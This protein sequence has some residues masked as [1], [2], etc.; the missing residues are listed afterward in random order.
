MGL[1]DIYT[2]FVLFPFIAYILA[3]AKKYGNMDSDFTVAR[4]IACGI[5]LDESF[6]QYRLSV[7]TKDETKSLKKGKLLLPDCFFLMGT[8]DPTGK[9][10]SDEVCVVL[11][12]LFLACIFPLY[13]PLQ[14][15]CYT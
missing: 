12:V 5:P 11:Y 7:L 2:L 6:L 3:V 1:V 14:I 10:K 15:Y 8:T 9:L 13:E 4:M